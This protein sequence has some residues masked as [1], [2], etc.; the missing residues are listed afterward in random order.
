MEKTDVVLI[1]SGITSCAV[2]RTLLHTTEPQCEKPQILI[3]EARTLC[4]GASGRNGGHMR[5]SPFVYF[6]SFRE[7][8]GV[9]AAKKMM[10]FRAA[11]HTEVLRVAA[12]EGLLEE[13]EFK[14]V[15]AVDLV[16]EEERWPDLRADLD[17]YMAHVSPAEGPYPGIYES[18]EAQKVRTSSPSF[19]CIWLRSSGFQ[20]TQSS[21]WTYIICCISQYLPLCDWIV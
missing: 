5:D 14:A 15:E 10:S 18:N 1:G 20:H 11:N 19:S 8:F 3:L 12:E 2:S 4:S 16:L 17:D 13:G 21:S 7:D 9:T 6:S